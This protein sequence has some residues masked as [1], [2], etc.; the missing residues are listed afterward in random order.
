MAQ[1]ITKKPGEDIIIVDEV[2]IPPD[3]PTGDCVCDVQTRN[4]Q[5]LSPGSPATAKMVKEGT[6]HFLELGIPQ[7]IQG[8]QGIPGSGTGGGGDN[9][10]NKYFNVMDYGATGNGSTDDRQAIQNAWNA[11][12]NARGTLI[13]PAA[14]NFY[15]INNTL[16]IVPASGQQAFA[17]IQSQG[18][19]GF[20]IVYFGPSGQPAVVIDGL[21]AGEIRGMKV[22]IG[23]GI[24]NSIGFDI[25]TAV[26][27]STGGFTMYDCTVEQ[28]TGQNNQGW[29]F[30]HIQGGGAD[31]SQITFVN[32]K[33]EGWKK[34]D[35]QWHPGQIG[36]NITGHNTL[37]MTWVGGAT[38]F[39]ET[40]LKLEEGGSLYFYG[41]QTSQL[42]TDFH[43]TYANNI[44][45]YGGRFE[46]GRK[47]LRVEA[48]GAMPMFAVRDAVI[49]DYRTTD[50]RLFDVNA[51][52]A[53][54]VEGC[55]MN[56]N[57]HP[58]DA[59]MFSMNAA[60]PNNFG[61]LLIKGGK[62]NGAGDI[63]TLNGFRAVV[64]NVTRIS[65]YPEYK[66]IGFFPNRLPTP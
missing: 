25:G 23:D 34:G 24:S 47:F 35:G 12:A 65:N 3:P 62:I 38:I 8:P 51:P 59:R 56:S 30:G 66:P 45:V 18:H 42:G 22:K 7:G 26:G 48:M 4:T 54:T 60:A 11:A 29:R 53:I 39:T 36:W 58:W 19:W 63:V 52:A 6:T 31:I 28:N 5:T 14:S 32:C 55:A 40:G 37:A 49:E 16:R 13:I 57:K 21:K 46:A 20:N 2:V 61:S 33:V 44:S 41:F 9:A 15:R 17:N 10:R 64:E 27:G 50:G 1:T 43:M